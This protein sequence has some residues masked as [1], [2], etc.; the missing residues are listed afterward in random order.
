MN[1]NRLRIIE[2]ILAIILVCVFLLVMDY[3]D[4]GYRIEG[5][6][7]LNSSR[8]NTSQIIKPRE[9]DINGQSFSRKTRTGFEKNYVD[10]EGYGPKRVLDNPDADIS[11]R[12]QIG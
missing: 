12:N 6:E 2:L 10:G 1:H 4:L 11:Y 9:E 8:S 7:D 5:A 3:F